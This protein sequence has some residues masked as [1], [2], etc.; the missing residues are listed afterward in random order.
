MSISVTTFT[1]VE[2]VFA[3]EYFLLISSGLALTVPIIRQFV[4]EALRS[5]SGVLKLREVTDATP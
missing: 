4:M 5:D 1:H 3:Q 2:N